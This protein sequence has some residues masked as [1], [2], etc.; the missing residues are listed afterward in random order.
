MKASNLYFSR[1]V[2][3][4]ASYPLV[5]VPS[6]YKRCI[7]SFHLYLIGSNIFY[8]LWGVCVCFRATHYHNISYGPSCP[9]MVVTILMQTSGTLLILVGKKWTFAL[10]NIK[11][12]M[13]VSLLVINVIYHWKENTNS[14]QLIVVL[15]DLRLIKSSTMFNKH[16]KTT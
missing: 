1:S 14:R 15:I 11:P 12:I 3:L 9:C 8:Y 4:I 5:S 2:S 10:Q 6:S 7:V 13:S 16:A